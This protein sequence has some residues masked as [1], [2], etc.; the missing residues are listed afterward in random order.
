MY[1]YL[2]IILYVYVYRCGFDL[3]SFILKPAFLAQEKKYIEQR[4]L[5]KKSIEVLSAISKLLYPH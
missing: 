3:I 1:V 2:Y 5:S 4:L